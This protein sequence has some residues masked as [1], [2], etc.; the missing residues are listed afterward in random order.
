MK[1]AFEPEAQRLNKDDYAGKD[2]S[3]DLVATPLDPTELHAE[4]CDVD[5]RGRPYGPHLAELNVAPSTST[6]LLKRRVRGIGYHD[7][8][9]CSPSS[10]RTTQSRHDVTTTPRS[11]SKLYRP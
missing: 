1:V 3:E 7:L 8:R 4:G 9:L 10:V 5:R 11:L 6:L 2:A